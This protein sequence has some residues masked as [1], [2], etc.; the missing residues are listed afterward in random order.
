MF[1]QISPALTG[2]QAL[3]AP[4]NGRFV[5]GQDYPVN[6]LV[7]QGLG[8][9]VPTEM[10]STGRVLALG[11]QPGVCG[12]LLSACWRPQSHGQRN[13]PTPL[14]SVLGKEPRAGASS[15]G[16]LVLQLVTALAVI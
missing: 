12:E 14:F 5:F 2:P 10:D 16:F 3:A 4:A 7:R 6:Y 8:Y 9:A 13:S 1:C 11:L 15:D